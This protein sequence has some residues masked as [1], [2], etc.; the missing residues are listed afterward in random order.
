M[1]TLNHDT[2]ISVM[3]LVTPTNSHFVSFAREVDKDRK[4]CHSSSLITLRHASQVCRSWRESI[5]STSAL[6]GDTIPLDH[7]NQVSH[8]W[9]EEVLKRTGT[10]P[11]SI[12]GR[13]LGGSSPAV[14]F[15]LRLQTNHWERMRRVSNSIS[16]DIFEDT[17]WS[18]PRNHS[19]VLEILNVHS[20]CDVDDVDDLVEDRLGEVAPNFVPKLHALVLCYAA[21]R[22]SNC[23]TPN[24]R[25]LAIWCSTLFT[26]FVDFMKQVPHL[27]ALTLNFVDLRE[28]EDPSEDHQPVQMSK[29]TSLGIHHVS[30]KHAFFILRHILPAPGAAVDVF[31]SFNGSKQ[32]LL[33]SQ[34]TSCLSTHLTE[35]LSIE[36]CTSVLII[37]SSSTVSP[38]SIK[39]HFYEP[40]MLETLLSSLA[41]C[42]AEISLI[43]LEALQIS[44]K[45]E[46]Y[47]R[48][49]KQHIRKIFLS[50]AFFQTLHIDWNGL[51]CFSHLV[52]T[53]KGMFP[54]MH[55]VVLSARNSAVP[56]WMIMDFMVKI[57]SARCPLSRICLKDSAV[58]DWLVAVNER[59][60]DDKAFRIVLLDR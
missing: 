25:H 49:A 24:L 20:L 39:I 55:T 30:H 12:I 6:W 2:F 15:F 7:L 52:A 18:K 8:Y 59:F 57:R 21:L 27:E 43:D 16:K 3:K 14:K 23:R 22:L 13:E 11:L 40:T 37:A 45:N 33:R 36:I 60:E 48:A 50:L 34:L 19:S 17:R 41:D 38:F 42:L 4:R 32:Q 54:R 31:T 1:P 5:L 56:A 46:I 10:S 29:L 44:F 28:T 51:P 9:R 35:I 26:S 47:Y 53:D 58:Y